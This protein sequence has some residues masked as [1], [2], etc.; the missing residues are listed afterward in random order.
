MADTSITTSLGLDASDVLS[1]YD[2]IAQAADKVAERIGNLSNVMSRVGSMTSAVQSFGSQTANSMNQAGSAAQSFAMNWQNVG[3]IVE[4]RLLSQAI[5]G[6]KSAIED[7]VGSAVK[8]G[9]ELARLSTMTGADSAALGQQVKYLA[10]ASAISLEQAAAAMTAAWR[11]N[12]GGL[13]EAHALM[14]EA[15]A[16]GKATGAEPSAAVSAIG[17]VIRSFGLDVGSAK[18]ISDEMLTISQKTRVGIDELGSAFGRVAPLARHLGVSFEEVGAALIV[19]VNEGQTVGTAMSNLERSMKLI[20]APSTQM[21][22]AFKTLGVDSATT[23][24]AAKGLQGAFEAIGDTT[25]G[26]A[27][28]LMKIGKG[29]RGAS[30]IMTIGTQSAKDY[31]QALDEIQNTKAGAAADAAAKVMES[32]AGRIEAA[33]TKIK[34][35]LINMGAKMLDVAAPVANALPWDKFMEGVGGA[36]I[37]AIPAVAGTLIFK[38]GFESKLDALQTEAAE[39]ARARLA[40]QA[41]FDTQFGENAAARMQGDLRAS[42]ALRRFGEESP[43]YA[44]AS[45]A[46]EAAY[47]DASRMQ[48]QMQASDAIMERQALEANNAA[49]AYERWGMAAKGVGV[50]LMGL[51]AGYIIGSAYNEQMQKIR[52]DINEAEARWLEAKRT[53]DQKIIDSDA[54]VVKRRVASALNASSDVAQTYQNELTTVKE[55][56]QEEIKTVDNKLKE[57][58][59][60]H[61]EYVQG[62]VSAEKEA[63]N[64]IDAG[65][66]HITEIEGK[67]KEDAFKHQLETQGDPLK[68]VQMLES[69]AKSVADEARRTMEEGARYG[70][71]EEIARGRAEFA[72]AQADA[73]E[74]ASKAKSLAEEHAT[75]PYGKAD[76]LKSDRDYNSALGWITKIQQEQI[77]AERSSIS[78][79]QSRIQRLNTEKDYQQSIT[80]AIEKQGKI[81]AE[82][83]KILDKEGNLKPQAE[84]DQMAAR[85]KAALDEMERLKFTQRDQAAAGQLGVGK[86]FSESFLR[87][88]TDLQLSVE[89][90]LARIPGEIQ[91]AFNNFKV[92]VNVDFA[93]LEQ[94]LG[95]PLKNLQDVTAAYM[96]AQQELNALDTKAANFKGMNDQIKAL[97]AGIKTTV[98]VANEPGFLGMANT[99]ALLTSLSDQPIVDKIAKDMIELSQNTRIADDDLE[100]MR[101][102]IGEIRTS[103]LNPATAGARLWEN[104]FEAMYAKLQ[105]IKTLQDQLKGEETPQQLD[106]R[107]AYLK[108]I[109]ENSPGGRVEQNP[110]SGVVQGVN[111][112]GTAAETAAQKLERLNAMIEAQSNAPAPVNVPQPGAPVGTPSPSDII[113]GTVN[114]A[115]GG[116]IY[117]ADGYRARGTDTIPAMLSPGEMVMSAQTVRHFG[118][119]LHAMNSGNRNVQG[120]SHGGSVTNVGDIHVSISGQHGVGPGTGRQI[121]SE[122]RRELR[123][124]SSTI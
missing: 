118:A 120:H 14:D 56:A 9:V 42:K 114:R 60:S 7:S 111:N 22:A 75:G 76:A 78:I 73:R 67:I 58:T 72:Q 79:Q 20:V 26:T 62:I 105:N 97:Q 54:E 11:A 101:V 18:K 23:L 102:R 103:R 64:E 115:S 83:S 3:K 86:A 80:D 24:L 77:S 71:K 121:A 55:N 19:A 90:S 36:A 37:S 13:K 17:G 30:E 91:T 65:W 92:H 51:A 93:Q 43:E 89:K 33:G 119:T 52:T 112:I 39:T 109:I 117:A 41:A 74:A 113:N 69:H 45:A 110:Y 38:K 46:R 16:L 48:Q 57:M 81:A 95:R 99:R 10:D 5:Y 66:K 50:A 85:R 116:M 108:S 31:K 47:A 15:A 70:N 63:M 94:V 29:A 124:G 1:A 59:A 12:V 82:N 27:E 35:T 96:K 106:Q 68:Q 88:P 40:N 61:K 84:L 8:L 25:A 98:D 6:I 87:Q 32:S 100:K 104:D 123:R 4:S 107:S 28:G 21:T 44:R 2:K 49:V 34:N 122:L 53:A